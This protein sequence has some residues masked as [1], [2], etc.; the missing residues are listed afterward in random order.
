MPENDTQTANDV[1]RDE[2]MQ[3]QDS[4]TNVHHLMDENGNVLATVELVPNF[5]PPTYTWVLT[6]RHKNG[7][8][9][10]GW[11]FGKAETQQAALNALSKVLKKTVSVKAPTE[12][13]RLP[14]EDEA[15]VTLL[16]RTNAKNARKIVKL[17]NQKV[18]LGLERDESG[19]V[20]YDEGPAILECIGNTMEAKP[21]DWNTLDPKL[22]A[23]LI[24]AAASSLTWRPQN[25]VDP[26]LIDEVFEE[27][28]W[29]EAMFTTKPE[30]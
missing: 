12:S 1:L 20:A 24:V 15:S 18:L 28:P 25:E 6:T 5:Y 16:V 2:N 27:F 9:I 11:E 29:F 4:P 10:K 7:K 17:S 13:I 23:S 21:P 3:W 26:E 30:A 14:S 22:Q 19:F 8:P